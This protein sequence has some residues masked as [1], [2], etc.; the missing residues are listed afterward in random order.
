GL[1]LG[2]DV[3]IGVD[4]AATHF[5]AERTYLLGEERLGSAQLIDRLVSWQRQYAIV[6]IEDGLAEEDW[7]SGPRLAGRLKGSA[8]VVGDDLR[9]PNPERIRKAI[10]SAAADTLL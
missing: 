2:T 7:E 10:A 4:V 5:Y 3:A 9:C 6:S 8:L 1:R